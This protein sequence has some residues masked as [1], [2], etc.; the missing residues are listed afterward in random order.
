MSWLKKFGIKA[1]GVIYNSVD[2][3]LYTQYKNKSYLSELE[4]KI[5]V[6]FAG[7][8]IKEKGGFFY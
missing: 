7:R 8:V 4:D 2:S 5:I 6:S 1:S 3:S